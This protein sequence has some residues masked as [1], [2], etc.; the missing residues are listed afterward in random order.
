MVSLKLSRK[1]KKEFFYL[2]IRSIDKNGKPSWWL[3]PYEQQKY[4]AG[5]YSTQDLLDWADNKGKVIKT[6]TKRR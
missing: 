1:A 3:N 2:K 4:E 5:W 6:C